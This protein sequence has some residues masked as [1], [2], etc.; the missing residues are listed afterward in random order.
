MATTISQNPFLKNDKKGLGRVQSFLPSFRV[1]KERELVGERW[2][3][4]EKKEL[5]I[6]DEEKQ[7]KQRDCLKHE[8][9]QVL[10][11]IRNMV[12]EEKRDSPE[13]AD[14]TKYVD[15]ENDRKTD[16]HEEDNTLEEMSD[17]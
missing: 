12:V 15:E 3:E 9:D 6:V 5:K 8:L 16:E 10:K 1:R 11:G 17:V 14:N 13:D 4:K 7:S 2:E